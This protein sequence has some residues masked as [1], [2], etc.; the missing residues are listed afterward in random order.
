MRG[1]SATPPRKQISKQVNRLL[2]QMTWAAS[3]GTRTLRSSWSL[4]LIKWWAGETE[5]GALVGRAR[6]PTSRQTATLQLHLTGRRMQR[7]SRM[8]RMMLAG[9]PLGIQHRFI[10]W[11]QM[12]GCG[13]VCCACRLFL[14][15]Q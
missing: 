8:Q 1:L 7:H 10:L 9:P 15:L 3:E 13:T 4:P 2:L 6:R 14:L 11:F 5:H 12:A